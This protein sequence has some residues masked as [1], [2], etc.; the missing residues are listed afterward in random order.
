MLTSSLVS[1][2]ALPPR[3]TLATRVVV[4]R[5]YLA[6]HVLDGIAADGSIRGEC[7]SRVLESALAL[8]LLQR[9]NAH[10]AAC[11]RI[12]GYLH[13]QWSADALDPFHHVLTASVLGWDARTSAAEAIET[14]LSSFEHHT[15]RRK[16]IFFSILLELVSGEDLQ[17]G[18]RPEHF[19]VNGEQRWVVVMMRAL[20]ILYFAQHG[21]TELITE[22]RVELL[23][24]TT[25]PNP[26]GTWEQYLLGHLLTL[27]ALS[28]LPAHASVVTRCIDALLEHQRPNGGFGFI[29]RMEIFASATAGLGLIGAG[30]DRGSLYAVG[31]F[32]A[33]H[34][35]PDGG[36]GYALGV[37]QTD[38]DDTAYCVEFLRS[39]N[40]TRYRLQLALAEQYI[41]NMQN[42]DG[43]FPT[44]A[45]GNASEVAMTAAALNALAP[46]RRRHR[47]V[48]RNAVQYILDNQNPDGT[49]E[50]SWSCAHSNAIFRAL[51]AIQTLADGRS[52]A[53]RMDA[54][55]RAMSYLRMSQNEDGG[56]GHL[57]GDDSDPI[58]SAYALITLS[59][60]DGE[61]TIGRGVDYLVQQ[62]LSNG[63]YLSRPDGSGPRPI[64]YDVPVL[65]DHFALIAL[66]HVIST[67]PRP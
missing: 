37:L 3:Q 19:A 51:L 39:L 40:P 58:S 44:F 60:F 5:N 63:G 50:R 14:Y 27:L 6:Q 13:S 29:T 52:A 59:H 23:L 57:I 25:G 7:D 17:L 8:L 12:V 66:D 41:L 34:Q 48:F 62:Q 10:P 61:F 33:Q 53:E 56:W 64:A 36:W 4:A 38:L 18:L 9:Q 46:S 67:H 20:E 11:E 45:R 1:V 54:E 2:R 21:Q 65:A 47:H 28:V 49:F 15:S 24:E 32:L 35:Q 31:D 30:I 22:D 55:R 16:R 42:R 43:G 26:G